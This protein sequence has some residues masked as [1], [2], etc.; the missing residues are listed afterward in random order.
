MYYICNRLADLGTPVI[1]PPQPVQ[2]QAPPQPAAPG[3]EGGDGGAAAGGGLAANGMV[4]DDDDVDHYRTGA[5]RRAQ[6]NSW[7]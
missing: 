4:D 3:D 5:A 1:G 6:A 7:L 2:A